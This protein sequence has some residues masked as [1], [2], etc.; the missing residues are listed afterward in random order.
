MVSPPLLS[1]DEL[2]SLCPMQR[3]WDHLPGSQLPFD[4]TKRY[5][6]IYQHTRWTSWLTLYAGKYKDLLVDYLSTLERQTLLQ[7]H[8]VRYGFGVIQD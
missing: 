8:D 4:L 1:T 2:S 6:P 3:P 7:V 5:H